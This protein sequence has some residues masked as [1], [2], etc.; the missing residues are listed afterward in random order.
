[1]NYKKKEGEESVF[2]F[3]NFLFVFVFYFKINFNFGTI[4]K[5]KSEIIVNF[6]FEID[7]SFH[8]CCTRVNV[9]RFCKSLTS[10]ESSG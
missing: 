7:I 1:M 3:E 6:N 5:I 10:S 9:S 8:F 4:F 2:N